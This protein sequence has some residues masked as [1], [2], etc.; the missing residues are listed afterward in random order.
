MWPYGW[1]PLPSL[2]QRCTLPSLLI[3]GLFPTVYPSAEGRGGRGQLV[4]AIT[5]QVVGTIRTG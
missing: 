2:M 4:G 5:V 1:N 3:L